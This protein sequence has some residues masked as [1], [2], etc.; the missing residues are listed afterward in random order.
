M[1]DYNLDYILKVYRHEE[2]YH[3]LLDAAWNIDELKFLI[4]MPADDQRDWY[5]NMV[6]TFDDEVRPLLKEDVDDIITKAIL[7]KKYRKLKKNAIRA[8]KD[9]DN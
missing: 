1:F 3:A 2:N 5:E 6:R 8:I 9:E 7:T 4:Q